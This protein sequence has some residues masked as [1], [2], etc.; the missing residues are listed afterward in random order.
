VTGLPAAP[1]PAPP[2]DAADQFQPVRRALRRWC[3]AGATGALRLVDPPGGSV[4]L[5]DGLIT[6]AESPLVCTVDE[7]L[8]VSG[9]LSPREWSAA[10]ARGGPD[11]AVG[12]ALV[13]QAA[14]S[15]VELEVTV[16]S[17]LLGAAL[18]QLDL[19]ATTEFV[20][21]ARHPVG[22]VRR[23][24]LDH[25]GTEVDRRRRRLAA[26]W[27]DDA[28]DTGPVRPAVRL[29][30][31]H[32][33]LSALQWEIVANAHRAGSPLGLARV[34]GRDPFAVLLEAR[35]LVR[36]GLLRPDQ[37]RSPDALPAGPARGESGR[38][39]DRLPRRHPRPR[40]P[41]RDRRRPDDHLPVATL[42]R[43]RRALEEKL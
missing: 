27:P 23:S 36:A 11:D 26:A 4:Y 43:I 10:V 17:V 38:D 40:G 22:P 42:L 19:V 37:A 14:L 41:T 25:V 24:T 20:P 39:A 12:R 28:V 34:L 5:V 18:F 3:A 32:V 16:L 13:E 31:H 33:A 30:G 21:D 2:A 29:P 8:V 9:R 15:Q 1:R 35:H 7:L 6:M